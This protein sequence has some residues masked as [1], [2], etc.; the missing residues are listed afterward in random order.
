MESNAANLGSFLTDPEFVASL[1]AYTV[2][3]RKYPIIPAVGR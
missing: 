3:Y 2:Y 1:I